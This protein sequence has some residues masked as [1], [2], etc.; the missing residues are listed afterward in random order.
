MLKAWNLGMSKE[1]VQ[2]NLCGF[3][4]YIVTWRRVKKVSTFKTYMCIELMEKICT[5]H[6]FIFLVKIVPQ[7]N[8]IHLD[9][10]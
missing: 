2:I 6:N 5:M 7:I 1:A 10:Q 9:S 4:K 8:L 3:F